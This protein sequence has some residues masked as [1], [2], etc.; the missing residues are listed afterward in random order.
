[1]TD[2]WRPVFIV[3][4]EKVCDAT[5]GPADSGLAHSPV[6]VF[7]V[8]GLLPNQNVSQLRRGCLALH[9]SC[10]RAGARPCCD[11]SARIVSA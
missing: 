5:G 3:S 4:R 7:N 8:K 11:N 9:G 10:A 2:G 6:S 1:M